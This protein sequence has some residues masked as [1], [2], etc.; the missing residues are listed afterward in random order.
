M[1]KVR[2]LL[3]LF[4]VAAFLGPLGWWA[5]TGAH[6]GWSMNRVP[7]T[8]IDE[9]TAIEYITYKER[10]VPGLDTLLIGSIA[11]IVLIGGSFFFRS[12]SSA[13]SHYD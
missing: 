3:H 8:Q 4:A 6:R 9:T 1:S 10:F 11:A 2:P 5:A 12:S 7:V 13:S